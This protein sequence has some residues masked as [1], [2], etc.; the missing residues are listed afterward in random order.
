MRTYACIFSIYVRFLCM[1]MCHAWTQAATMNV[2]NVAC[3]L[4][5]LYMLYALHA[6]MHVRRCMRAYVYMYVHTHRYGRSHV[7]KHVRNA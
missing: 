4:Y 1:C 6:C 2:N 3:A 7:R 5:I